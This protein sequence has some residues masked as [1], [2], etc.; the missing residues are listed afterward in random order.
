MKQRAN[1]WCH[2]LTSEGL[3]VLLSWLLQIHDAE[4]NLASCTDINHQISF[5]SITSQS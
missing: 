1:E 3:A 2:Q 4:L 5:F